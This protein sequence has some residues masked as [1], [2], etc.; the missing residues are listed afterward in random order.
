MGFFLYSGGNLLLL[1]L[2]LVYLSPAEIGLWYTFVS[3]SLLGMLFDLGFSNAITRNVSYAV[4]GAKTINKEG[5][6]DT[7]YSG[8]NYELLVRIIKISRIFYSSLSLLIFIL[9][10]S[11][12][13][14]YVSSVISKDNSLSISLAPWFVYTLAT[15]INLYFG[16]WKPLLKGFG[17]IKESQKVR[18]MDKLTQLLLSAIFLFFGFGVLGIAL[19]FLIGSVSARFLAIYYFNN[20]DVEFRKNISSWNKKVTYFEDGN[21]VV[22]RNLLPNT[23]KQALV[24]ISN[25]FTL[26]GM[27]LLSSYYLGLE[28]SAV[29]GLLQQMLTTL[30][31]VSNTLFNTYVPLLGS[32]LTKKA[33]EDARSYLFKAVKIQWLILSLGSL[34]IL[35]SEPIVQVFNEGIRYF[36]LHITIIIILIYVLHNNHSLFSTYISINNYFPHSQSFILSTVIIIILQVISLNLF[37]SIYSLILPLL[38]VN[39][40]YNNWVWPYKVLARDF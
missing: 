4:S 20:Y 7:E 29:L 13:S 9:F 1:P 26:R 11:L 33:T 30:M 35:F 21:K 8:P 17:A 32:L 22:A 23:Y 19:G 12:G 28:T 31:Q 38:F 39:L 34:M 25:F 6:T 37:N 10:V 18:V 5:L 36:P 40:V 16:Y 24:S 15:S 27:T 14:L 2:A 3:L